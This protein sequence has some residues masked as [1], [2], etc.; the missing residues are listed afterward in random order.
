MKGDIKR[1]A[2]EISSG[3][4]LIIFSQ[5]SYSVAVFEDINERFFATN[6]K[7][8]NLELGRDGFRLVVENFFGHKDTV[9]TLFGNSKS[10]N[11]VIFSTCTY[12]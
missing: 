12:Y 10:E 8:N 11:H 2:F 4:F 7:M 1:R 3:S 6:R 5:V 9:I